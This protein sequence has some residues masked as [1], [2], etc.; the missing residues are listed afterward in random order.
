M[1]VRVI[2]T[3]RDKNTRKIHKAEDEITVSKERF[4]EINS[5]SFGILVEEI[6]TE[7][8]KKTKSKGA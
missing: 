2:K 5:T 8:S 6:K 7:P 1:K 3:F 4:E